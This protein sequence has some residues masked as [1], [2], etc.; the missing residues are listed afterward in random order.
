MSKTQMVG[1]SFRL[2]FRFQRHWDIP[3]ASAFFCG[4]LGAGL[5]FVSMIHDF[6]PGLVLGL[7]I[8]GVGKP[9]FHL[10]HM[11]V[12]AQSWRAVLRPDRSWTSRGLIAI[13]VFSGAGALH[14]INVISGNTIPFDIVFQILAGAAAL[15]VMTYQGFAMSHSTAIA[16]WSTAMMPVS[17]LFYALTG[18]V[19]VTLLLQAN[20]LAPEAVSRLVYMA[21]GLLLADL[22]MLLGIL[23]DAYRGSPGGRLS[24]ELLIKTLYAKWFHGAV[25][26]AGILLPLA[27]LSVGSDAFVARLLAAAGVLAGFYAFRVLIFK[28]GVYEPVMSF[29]SQV[30]AQNK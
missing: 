20:S 11:G 7:L 23:R 28:A 13:V 21:Q 3:M 1:D 5:Y 4:E 18:G 22:I 24:A 17:S 12:P 25:L 27:A 19:I 16:L 2:G 10:T 29:S 26:V 8:T 9:F 14:T 6:T 15:I 30:G